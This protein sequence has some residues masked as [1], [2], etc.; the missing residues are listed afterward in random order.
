MQIFTL[1]EALAAAEAE[2]RRATE[3]AYVTGSDNLQLGIRN[4]RL[5]SCINVGKAKRKLL[6]EEKR[7][8]KV[9]TPVDTLLVF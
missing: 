5:L 8:L 2:A 4:G 7:Q 1:L 6:R 3:D 9:C